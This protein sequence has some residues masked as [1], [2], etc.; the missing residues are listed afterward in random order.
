MKQKRAVFLL[1]PLIFLYSGCAIDEKEVSMTYNLNNGYGDAP[2]DS[3]A[4][5]PGSEVVVLPVPAGVAAPDSTAF[6]GWSTAHDGSGTLYKPEAVFVINKNT[7]LYALWTGTGTDPDYPKLAGTKD[8][9]RTIGATGHFALADN[10]DD[11]DTVLLELGVFTG[12][13][14]GRGHKI[15]LNIDE[16]ETDLEAI[17]FIARTT[18][19]AEIKNLHVAGTIIVSNSSSTTDRLAVGGIVGE[20]TNSGVLKNCRSTVNITVTSDVPLYAGGLA[21]YAY[22]GIT[23]EYCYYSG[24]IASTYTGVETGHQHFS[25]GISTNAR[26]GA[27]FHTVSEAA[28]IWENTGTWGAPEGARQIMSL[29]YGA[30]SAVDFIENYARGTISITDFYQSLTSQHPANGNLDG[31]TATLSQLGDEVWWRYAAGWDAVWGGDLPTS[32]RPWVWDA[33][34]RRP[35]LHTFD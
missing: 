11:V 18:T 14:D 1:L 4:Y 17:G 31:T 19:G 15:T 30:S 32:A 5:S 34:T 24:R 23:A 33:A 35:K 13:F 28:L 29:P 25:G 10:V 7:T 26:S 6:Y 3:N 22:E 20:M 8:E 12:K 21:G 27:I 2:V 9:L 16:S